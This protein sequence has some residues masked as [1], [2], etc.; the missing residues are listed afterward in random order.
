MST[1]IG[2]MINNIKNTEQSNIF[3]IK[4]QN[5]PTSRSKNPTLYHHDT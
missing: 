5:S 3:L 4:R 2:T 1:H